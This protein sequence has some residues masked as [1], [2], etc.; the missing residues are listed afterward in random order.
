[1]EFD[2]FAQ[3]LQQMSVQLQQQTIYKR[4]QTGTG[5]E[6]KKELIEL[7]N[8]FHSVPTTQ[9]VVTGETHKAHPFW[10]I[11]EIMTEI[12]GLN[13]PIMTKYKPEIIENS[14]KLKPDKRVC[15]SYGERWA[16]HNQLINIID[17]LSDRQESKR[18]VLATYMPYDTN[19]TK[20]DVPCTIMH[21]FLIRDNKMN[22][23]TFFRSHDF[24]S[25]QK[26]DVYLSSFLSQLITMGVNA[27]TNSNIE[28]GR[29]HFYD[30]SLHVYAKDIIKLERVQDT[31]NSECVF[32]ILY[33]Y[34]KVEDIYQDLVLLKHSEE[35]SY[36]GKF[37]AS[38]KQLHQIQNP[39]F[40]DFARVYFNRN[41]KHNGI[42]SK[43]S[44]ETRVLQW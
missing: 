7:I 12:F 31:K 22:T 9:I 32:D 1:M 35:A 21:Q 27:Q 3:L 24:M 20:T 30:G 8:Q 15:Y 11:G 10:V 39:A 37:D 25:G 6:Y 2:N 18:A 19:P 38:L 14:Y 28:N 23:T 5:D 13:P 44:Y 41:A 4:S 17:I 40:R 42:E 29:L 16:E 26:Y 34:N 36:W 33:K 43:L